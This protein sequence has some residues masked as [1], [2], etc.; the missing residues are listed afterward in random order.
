MTHQT[1]NNDSVLTYIIAGMGSWLGTLQGEDIL[2]LVS[3]LA[4]LGRAVYDTVRFF[5]YLGDRKDDKRAQHTGRS[6]STKS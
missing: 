5:H 2:V 4:V 1:E 6:K 3:I